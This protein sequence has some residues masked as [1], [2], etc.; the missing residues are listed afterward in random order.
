MNGDPSQKRF[1]Q[2]ARH[3]AI[4]VA[5]AG[6]A[7]LLLVLAWEALHVLLLMF[8]AILVA[9]ILDSGSRLL[10]AV[11]PLPR[12]AT[13]T[14]TCLVIVG[15]GFA[16]GFFAGPAI[17]SQLSNLLESVPQAISDLRSALLQTTW[18]G[19]ILQRVP[20][21][22][23]MFTA[24]SGAQIAA[25]FGTTFGVV[26]ETAFVLF[27]GLYLAVSP[28]TYR[29]GFVLLIPPAGR[30]RAEEVLGQLGHDLRRWLLAQLVAMAVIGT[31]FG[32][33]LAV[34]GVPMALALGVMA[35]VFAFVPILGPLAALIPALLVAF[36]VGPQTALYVL[37]LH[38]GVQVIES[39]LVTPLVQK[40]AVELPPFLLFTAQLLMAFAAGLL[41][42][43]V[44]TPLLVVVMVLVR[45]VYVEGV[46][47]DAPDAATA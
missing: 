6:T 47:G 14:L 15:I 26:G 4:A 43:I 35:G 13:L 23:E 24:D 30:D 18:G 45:M 25:F 19:E 46:L 21:A 8:S 5:I 3:V 32:V 9:V 31:L 39:Y 16:F 44:A 38:M 10:Q 37:I 22:K 27:A 28:D 34:I 42:V 40:R 33:G 20:E 12:W 41:G 1:S 2:F 7:A 11:T 17:V 36:S 29:R